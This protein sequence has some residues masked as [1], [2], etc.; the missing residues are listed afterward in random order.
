MTDLTSY[1]PHNVT[2]DL[3]RGPA[4]FCGVDVGELVRKESETPDQ[5]RG[6]VARCGIVVSTGGQS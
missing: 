2:P 1:S 5:V 6:D 3:I 4:V